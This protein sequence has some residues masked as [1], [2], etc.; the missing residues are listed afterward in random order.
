TETGPDHDKR[1]TAVAVVGEQSYSPGHGRSK[2]QAE[3][4]AAEAAFHALTAGD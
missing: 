3:Q 1:F 2:K 4:Q